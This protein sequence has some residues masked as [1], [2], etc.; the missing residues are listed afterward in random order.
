MTEPKEIL[1][2]LLQKRR[3]AGH[4]TPEEF[5]ALIRAQDANMQ[6]GPAVGDLIPD[7][8]LADANGRLWSRADLLGPQGLVLAFH[9]SADW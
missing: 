7:F 4:L 3:E 2:T 8:T 5:E 6:T 9:R 1:R